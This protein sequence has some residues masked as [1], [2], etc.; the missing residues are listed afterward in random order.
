MGGLGGQIRPGLNDSVNGSIC[1]SIYLTRMCIIDQFELK[2][3]AYM[4]HRKP[5]Q[6]QTIRQIKKDDRKYSKYLKG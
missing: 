1:Q 2:T 4:S 5:L 3:F 6:T